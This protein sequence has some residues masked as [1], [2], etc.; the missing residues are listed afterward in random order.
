MNMIINCC[1][2]ITIFKHL[3]AALFNEIALHFVRFLFSS[4]VVYVYIGLLLLVDR[5]VNT[6]ALQ[7]FQVIRRTLVFNVFNVFNDFSSAIQ[8][9]A[10]PKGAM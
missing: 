3:F 10:P 1:L 5:H 4:S 7:Y 6:L 8:L 2:V 9:C